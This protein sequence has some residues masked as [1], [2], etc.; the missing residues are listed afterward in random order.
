MKKILYSFGI[1][2]CL[3]ITYSCGDNIEAT[4]EDIE[5]IELLEKE[6]EVDVRSMSDIDDTSLLNQFEKTEKYLANI[7]ADNLKDELS[8]YDVQRLTINTDEVVIISKI[9]GKKDYHFTISIPERNGNE[10]FNLKSYLSLNF[11]YGLNVS[12]QLQTGLAGDYF[13]D[14]NSDGTTVQSRGSDDKPWNKPSKAPKAVICRHA[15]S[16]IGLNGYCGFSPGYCDNE[17]GQCPP[18]QWAVDL[19]NAI[20]S[21]KNTDDLVIPVRNAMDP[22]RNTYEITFPVFD[23]NP[24]GVDVTLKNSFVLFYHQEFLGQGYFINYNDKSE[25][26]HI[27]KESFIKS[28]QKWLYKLED[29]VPNTYYEIANNPGT[30]MAI[31]NMFSAIHQGI[32]MEIGGYMNRVTYASYS[33]D[34]DFSCLG[35]RDS[36]FFNP[37]AYTAL[38]QLNAGT[39]TWTQFVAGMPACN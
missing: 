17:N 28:F 1:A 33:P 18:P 12:N 31:F 8:N 15:S 16:L 19:I 5:S 25:A 26:H 21:V 13:L 3:L 35:A 37:S 10:E 23:T 2:C 38:Q 24:Y 7:I 4:I 29:L 39:I 34:P 32:D 22:N 9:N 6:I 36:Y 11:E 20:N 30:M 27:H 14:F